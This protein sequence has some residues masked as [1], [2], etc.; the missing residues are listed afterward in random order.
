MKKY[1]FTNEMVSFLV[2]NRNMNR[3]ELAVAFN[4]KFNLDFP[5]YAVRQELYKHVDTR[6]HKEHLYT[7]E[8]EAFI[9][10]NADVL[11]RKELVQR[12]NKKFN[13]SLS[14]N[15][16]SQKCM[17]LG[18]DKKIMRITDE[19]VLFLMEHFM[20]M[21]WESLC[22]LF[23]R[24]YGTSFNMKSLNRV[25]YEQGFT[26]YERHHFTDEQREFL[27]KNIEKCSYPKLTEE[28]NKKFHTACTLSSITQ[29]CL[30]FLKIKKADSYVPHNVMA[31][32]AETVKYKNS[33][34]ATVYVK[35]KEGLKNDKSGMWAPKQKVIWEQHNRSVRD[36]EVVVFLDG[37]KTNLNPDNLYCI[38]RKIMRIMNLNRWFA[39]SREHTLTAIKW[40]ELY[41][42]MYG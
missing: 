36:D 2:D 1:E 24:T 30:T 17:K 34:Y 16:I 42:A 8:Q 33:E 31:A 21:T 22:D 35:V 11:S 5:E 14:Y 39:K 27:V 40:C 3:K 41:Y 12:F 6:L 15:A 18:T 32:G 7:D 20:D 10:E 9:R 26:K 37:D 29:Q 13:T 28:F 19:Q 25:L 38:S 23:N 4:R